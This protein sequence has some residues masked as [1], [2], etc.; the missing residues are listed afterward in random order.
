M[1]LNNV[2]LRTRAPL[3]KTFA[4]VFYGKNQETPAIFFFPTCNVHKDLPEFSTG[5]KKALAKSFITAT[6]P[7]EGRFHCTKS[8]TRV[9][10]W[11]SS[12]GTLLQ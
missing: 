1:L 11:G 6:G 12:D 4:R 7:H 5:K 8:M 2:S 3:H 9:P 10:F